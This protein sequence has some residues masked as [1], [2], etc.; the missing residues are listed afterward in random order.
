MKNFFKKDIFII[1]IITWFLYSLIKKGVVYFYNYKIG[2]QSFSGIIIDI[3]I[4]VV[5]YITVY[6]VFHIFI[7]K[8]NN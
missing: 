2:L 7:K 1:I 8:K 5:V 4:W 3:I 6:K